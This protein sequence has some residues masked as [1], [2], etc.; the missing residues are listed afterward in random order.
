MAQY[1]HRGI[2]NGFIDFITNRVST[3]FLP[4]YHTLIGQRHTCHWVLGSVTKGDLVGVQCH[5]VLAA[6]KT[7]KKNYFLFLFSSNRF[8]LSEI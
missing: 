7:E 8:G 3:G 6:E 4:T 1:T 2:S 5:N